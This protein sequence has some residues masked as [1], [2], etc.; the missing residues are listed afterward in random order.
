MKE[1]TYRHDYNRAQ[2]QD[3]LRLPMNQ[4]RGYDNYR[5]DGPYTDR[6]YDRRDDR[7]GP[8]DRGY[9]RRPDDRNGPYTDRGDYNRRGTE[10]PYIDK[11]HERRD[12]RNSYQE[13]PQRN[14]PPRQ[15][16]DDPQMYD[17]TRYGHN[18]TTQKDYGDFPSNPRNPRDR[19]HAYRGEVD[20]EIDAFHNK[21]KETPDEQQKLQ[22]DGQYI[23]DIYLRPEEK[24]VRG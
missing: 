12:E 8:L 22:T 10:D 11:R 16:F 13:R 14:D 21:Q 4:G 19:P 1:S 7:N 5:Q 24:Q 2:A 6:N 17:D 15:T 3:D 23:D 18:R 20:K 9:D